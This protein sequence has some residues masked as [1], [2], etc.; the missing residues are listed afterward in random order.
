MAWVLSLQGLRPGTRIHAIICQALFWF[1]MDDHPVVLAPN[2]SKPCFLPTGNKHFTQKPNNCHRHHRA[3]QSCTAICKV[4]TALHRYG[5]HGSQLCSAS[6]LI[7]YKSFAKWWA[8][9]PCPFLRKFVTIFAQLVVTSWKV[10]EST[11]NW[12]L[13]LMSSRAIIYG[14]S[15]TTDYFQTFWHFWALFGWSTSIKVT[16][17]WY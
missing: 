10:H 15:K 8:H 1:S 5:R 17:I 2:I 7:S 4:F 16:M 3:A 12:I 9:K 11:R 13:F 6:S 14:T